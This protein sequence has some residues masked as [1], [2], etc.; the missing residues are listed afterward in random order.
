MLRFLYLLTI[1][2]SFGLMPALAGDLSDQSIRTSSGNLLESTQGLSSGNSL[3][4]STQAL[5]SGNKLSAQADDQ[6]AELPPAIIIT[7]EGEF[8]PLL[9]TTL[10]R[11]V[12][13]ALGEGVE[14]IVFRIKSP[15]G[16]LD[17]TYDMCRY[18]FELDIKTIAFVEDNAYSA[19]ALFSLSCDDLYMKPRSSIGDCEPIMMSSD[20]YKTMGAKVQ[21]PL[22]ERFR[23]FADENGYPVV[24]SEAMVRS[25]LEILRLTE[26]ASGNLVFM[27]T[28]DY[29]LYSDEEKEQYSD[30][31]IACYKGELLTISEK[32]ALELGF[33]SGTFKDP[34]ALLEHLGYRERIALSDLNETESFINNWEGFAP[35]LLM[36]AIFCLYL[37]FKTPGIGIF[38]ALSAVAFAAFFIGKFYQGQANYLEVMLFILGVALI[39]LELFVFP[40]FGLPGIAGT[41]LVLISLVLA[42]QDFSLPSTDANMD[43]FIHNLATVC[44][45]FLVPTFLFV[46]ILFVGPKS[47][48]SGPLFGLFHNS[49]QNLHGVSEDE[50]QAQVSAEKKLVGVKGVTKTSLVP[51]GKAEIEG[52][53]MQVATREGWI[54]EGVDIV[55][56]EQEGNQLM[57][58]AFDKIEERKSEET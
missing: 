44:M 37:E 13:E 7:I 5:S 15:G 42:M 1:C 36:I 8:K 57:V 45:S 21:S 14:L 9:L 56:V 31:K 50:T 32:E 27:R 18:V 52:R 41:I 22:M 58:S 39:F 51:G 10:E 17:V 12:D 35:M 40:G 49:S 38:G 11:R 23:R 54:D 46:A 4:E 33:S 47:T 25:E 28:E 26:K 16:R 48:A 6:S 19:A 3:F 55:V 24:L 30:K 43:E 20:G 2:F 53:L 29:N 34:Q